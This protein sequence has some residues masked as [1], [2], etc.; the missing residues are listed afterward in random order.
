MIKEIAVCR[1]KIYA[2]ES[3]AF[4]TEHGSQIIGLVLIS[5]RHLCDLI[6]TLVELLF[7]SRCCTKVFAMHIAAMMEHLGMTTEY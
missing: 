4:S 2:L 3:I 5:W 1:N 6:E 7:L